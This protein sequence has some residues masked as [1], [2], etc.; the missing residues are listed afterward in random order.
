MISLR[1]LP[2]AEREYREARGWYE[3]Q[4]LGL[5]SKVR[6]AVDATLERVQA[7]PESFPVV[8]SSE[9][10]QALVRRFPYAIYYVAADDEVLVV[11]VFHVRRNPRVWQRR[12]N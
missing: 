5:G 7:F 8:W 4:Q 6:D 1:L 12:T 11:S 2:E 3:D 9:V 10:R